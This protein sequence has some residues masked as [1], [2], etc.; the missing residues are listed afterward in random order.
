MNGA[1][2][3]ENRGRRGVRL[4]VLWLLTSVLWIAGCASPRPADPR[5]PDIYRPA[6]PQYP[7]PSRR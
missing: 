3:T 2:N 6:N 1:Q 7:D 5:D 4:A